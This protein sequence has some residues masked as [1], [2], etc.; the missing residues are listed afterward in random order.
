MTEKQ[1]IKMQLLDKFGISDEP[2]SVEFCRE[3][4]K[5]LA[6]G[7][8]KPTPATQQAVSGFP[9]GI[10]LILNGGKE[11]TDYVLFTPDTKDGIEKGQINACTGIGIKQGDWA[12]VVD[13]HDAADG[14]DVELTDAKDETDY[15]GYIDNYLDAVADW[16]GQDNTKHLKAIGLNED[17]V[18]KDGQ[19]IP[20]LG[21]MLFVFMNRKA[22]NEALE[23]VGG[24]PIEDIWYWTSTEYSATGAWHLPLGNGSVHY[25][26]TKASHAPRVRAVSAFL[27]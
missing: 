18:L 6:E 12:L 16:K 7:E 8:T 5:F 10:Y 3:A 21:E 9:N 1:E 2:K 15:D 4:Y 24:T 26:F 23:F 13:L 22:I 11:M 25:Y 14:E 20:A 17:I 27:Y 19:Y